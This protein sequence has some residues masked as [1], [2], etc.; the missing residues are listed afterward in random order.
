ML[1][2]YSYKLCHILHFSPLTPPPTTTTH[3]KVHCIKNNLNVISSF[4]TRNDATLSCCKARRRARVDIEDDNEDF[5][6][7]EEIGILEF[8]SQSNR[9][10]ALLVNAL[11]D[12]QEVEVLI[13]KGYSSCLSYK[14]SPDP[15]KSVLPQR[16]VIR[17]IDRI[18]GPFD[19]TNID[20]IE[21]GLTWES[22]RSRIS[23]I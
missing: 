22:F 12:D 18:R 1:L 5:G 8:Y 11:V 17:S 4:E 15:S 7:N 20:Y 14:T 21:K 2:N 9:E 16:A 10:E 19:P 6:Y 23:T 13:F 3:V